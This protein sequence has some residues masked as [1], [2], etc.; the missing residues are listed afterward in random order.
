MNT[1][2]FN[3]LNF[4]HAGAE[5]GLQ[6]RNQTIN[7]VTLTVEGQT[8]EQGLYKLLVERNHEGEI[9]EMI[10]MKSTMDDCNEIPNEGHA[11][12]SAR[13]TLTNNN[14][15]AETTRHTNSLFFVKKNPS[16]EC[17]EVFK[18][19]QLLPEDINLS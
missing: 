3:L 6:C 7:I 8:D 13:I 19:L 9:C 12:E 4:I 18:E 10:L 16:P 14:G 17:D 5:V 2:S 1:K 11:K 15:I